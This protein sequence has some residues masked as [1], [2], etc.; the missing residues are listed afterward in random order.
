MMPDFD[1]I[2]MKRWIVFDDFLFNNLRC[3]THDKKRN[4]RYS[5]SINAGKIVIIFCFRKRI[6]IVI[7]HCQFFDIDC[8]VFSLKEIIS[9]IDSVHW[10]AVLQRDQCTIM[11]IVRMRNDDGIKRADFPFMKIRNETFFC[12]IDIH[13]PTRVDQYICP[14]FSH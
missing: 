9:C 11:I 7:F 14:S 8:V 6:K 12:Q 4:I 13:L 1:N 5:K 3:I 2:G 10:K